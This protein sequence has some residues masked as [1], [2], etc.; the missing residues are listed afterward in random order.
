MHEG[1]ILQLWEQE[2]L[3]QGCFAFAACVALITW[4]CRVVVGY[5]GL[6]GASQQNHCEFVVHWFR[7]HFDDNHDGLTWEAL[8][9]FIRGLLASSLRRTS[10]RQQGTKG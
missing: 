7:W 9:W 3:P 8:N 4:P 6:V 2:S 10:C 1:R 5:G